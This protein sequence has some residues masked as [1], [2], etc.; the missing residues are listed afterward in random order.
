LLTLDKNIKFININYVK[1][2]LSF[3]EVFIMK[4]NMI[5]LLVSIAFLIFSCSED[6][7]GPSDN[8][9]DTYEL[10]GTVKVAEG[11]EIQD[12]AAVYCVWKAPMSGMYI[13]GKSSIDWDK[14]SFDITLETPLPDDCYYEDGLAFCYILAFPHLGYFDD[15]NENTAYDNAIGNAGNIGIVLIDDLENEII[16]R[17]F[18]NAERGFVM[19]EITEDANG[20]YSFKEIT[21][22]V[23]VEITK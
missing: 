10:S 4:K 14:M 20:K 17:D 9:D 13:H 16:A 12:K 2:F 18:P 22:S 5:L 8:L 11:V 7:S 3:F 19:A 15:I 1:N 21:T 23:E 6:S